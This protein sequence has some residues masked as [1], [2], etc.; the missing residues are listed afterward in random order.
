MLIVHLMFIHS[1]LSITNVIILLILGQGRYLHG[2]TSQLRQDHS[3][4]FIA[5]KKNYKKKRV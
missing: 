2:L 4:Y 5:K 3:F 1:T